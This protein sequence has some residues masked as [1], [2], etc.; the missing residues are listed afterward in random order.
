MKVMCLAQKK[1]CSAPAKGHCIVFLSMFCHQMA[2]M[3]IQRQSLTKM[4]YWNDTHMCLY[5][6]LRCPLQER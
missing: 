1:Q 6:R 3:V 5:K 4:S 2:P